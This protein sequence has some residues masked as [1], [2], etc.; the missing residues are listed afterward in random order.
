[1]LDQDEKRFTAELKDTPDGLKLLMA[2]HEMRI[3]C[4]QIERLRRLGGNV[5]RAIDSW[6]RA[7]VRAGDH[8]SQAVDRLWDRY[9]WPAYG[10]RDRRYEWRPKALKP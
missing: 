9:Q 4:G 7:Y 8:A 10:A 1:M 6:R 3:A 2:I 5:S